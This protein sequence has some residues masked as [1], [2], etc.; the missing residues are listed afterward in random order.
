MGAELHL[1][2]E[3]RRKYLNNLIICY[4]NIKGVRNKIADF[5]IIIQSLPLDY[6][7]LSETKLDK[8]GPEEIEI[9]IVVV[10]LNLLKRG[11]ICNRI[12]DFELSFP[13]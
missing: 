4:W 11:I 5:Q 7:V 13:E 2:Q 12:S 3:D 9:K 10:L 1:L 6:V 8:Y